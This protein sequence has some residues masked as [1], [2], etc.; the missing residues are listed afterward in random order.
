MTKVQK[1]YVKSTAL[2]MLNKEIPNWYLSVKFSDDGN[3]EYQS[4][5]HITIN[6]GA[7]LEF[8]R[9]FKVQKQITNNDY[10]KILDLMK[11]FIN[12]EDK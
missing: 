10:L 1:M 4:N 3:I 8:L 7:M 9:I 12:M 6:V 11:E 5:V 2:T